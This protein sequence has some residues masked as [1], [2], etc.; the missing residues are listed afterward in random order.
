MMATMTEH[1]TLFAAPSAAVVEAELA[2]ERQAI[3]LELAAAEARLD[4]LDRQLA[5]LRA[6]SVI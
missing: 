6:G 3:R 5:A 1:R 2:A 4:E